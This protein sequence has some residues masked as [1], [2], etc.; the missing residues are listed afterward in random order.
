MLGFSRSKV[1]F[2]LEM[3]WRKFCA[4]L[5]G[6]ITSQSIQNAISTNENDENFQEL[7]QFY[8]ANHTGT[9]DKCL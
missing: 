3:S 2:A 6:I 5:K 7:T 4:V 8:Q 9:A 1:P